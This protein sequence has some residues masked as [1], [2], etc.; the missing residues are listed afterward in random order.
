LGGLKIRTWR[1][2]P[3]AVAV[4]LLWACVPYARQTQLEEQLLE[5]RRSQAR[6]EQRLVAETAR[7][8][9]AEQELAASQAAAA[10]YR[11]RITTLAARSSAAEERALQ[12][13]EQVTALQLEIQKR[14]T[15]IG[16][17]NRVIRLLD[18][19]KETIETSLR[20]Q[21][22]AQKIKLE[23]IDGRLKMIFV[24]RILFDSGSAEIQEE[25]KQLLLKI[26]EILNRQ[27]ETLIVIEG[28]TDSLPIAPAARERFPSNW[29]L[30]AARASAVARFLA[31]TAGLD[32][33][34]LAASGFSRYR[35]LA[36]NDTAEGRRQNRRIE[37]FFDVLR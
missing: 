19:T 37:I 17:Q 1:L 14:N 7:R 4:A 27:Q 15:A 21:L 32:P 24:D 9:Q 18:D 26:A 2:V 16:L 11:S 13:T 23:E 8:R 31:E 35:P 6:V 25:G 36:S 3:L 10:E 33:R 5:Q 29:E 30:S 12:L 22:S 34:R 28:H 20:E